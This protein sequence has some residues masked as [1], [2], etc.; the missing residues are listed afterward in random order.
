MSSE[1]AYFRVLLTISTITNNVVANSTTSMILKKD[2]AP[3]NG[4]CSVNTTTG[5]AMV[6]DFS[7]KCSNWTSDDGMIVQYEY[8]GK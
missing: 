6:T 1:S 5:Y 3:A 8:Y 2:S 4:R 7:I